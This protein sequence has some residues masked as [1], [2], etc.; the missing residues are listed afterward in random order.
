MRRQLA[1]VAHRNDQARNYE[2]LAGR[3]AVLNWILIANSAGFAMKDAPMNRDPGRLAS[4]LLNLR[5]N[6][7]KADGDDENPSIDG[8]VEDKVDRLVELLRDH[9]TFGRDA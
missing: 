5:A 9:F 4:Y 7:S 1:E 6:D 8:S 3:P 2:S